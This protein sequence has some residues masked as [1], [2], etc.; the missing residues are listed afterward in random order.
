[1]SVSPQ[2]RARLAAFLA[3][4]SLLLKEKESNKNNNINKN[5]N[6][7][8]QTSNKSDNFIDKSNKNYKGLFVKIHS[9]GAFKEA[10]SWGVSPRYLYACVRDLGEYAV[11]EVI[12]RIGPRVLSDSYFRQGL[13]VAQQRGRLFSYEMK[14]L[15]ARKQGG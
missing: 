9:D 5:N 3:D 2:Q 13:P 1:M 12:H 8:N 7:V 15:L 4:S 14:Q 10:Q 6:F 11:K